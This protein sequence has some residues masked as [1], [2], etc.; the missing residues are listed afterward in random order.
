[1]NSRPFLRLICFGIIIEL[2]TSDD[3][4]AVSWLSKDIW[5]SETEASSFKMPYFCNSWLWQTFLFFPSDGCACP[6]ILTDLAKGNW[7][8]I[9]WQ[10]NPLG[11][12]VVPIITIYLK[13]GKLWCDTLFTLVV[14]LSNWTIAKPRPLYS[15]AIVFPVMHF[16]SKQKGWFDMFYDL[17]ST[18]MLQ[19]IKSWSPKH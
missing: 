4:T 6:T 5:T 19:V 16:Q 10:E 13:W 3:K 12:N 17:L 14:R 2:A 7:S 1:M 11:A 8:G 9:L 15:Q 18:S